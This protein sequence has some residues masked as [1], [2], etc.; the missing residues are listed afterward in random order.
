MNVVDIIIKFLVEFA[1]D[2]AVEQISGDLRVPHTFDG[3]FMHVDLTE[4]QQAYGSKRRRGFGKVRVVLE[5]ADVDLVFAS[6]FT[7]VYWVEMW[8][9][10]DEGL[11]T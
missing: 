1:F 3:T 6:S 5:V 11:V 10:D 2:F 7:C 9:R 4:G 8:D